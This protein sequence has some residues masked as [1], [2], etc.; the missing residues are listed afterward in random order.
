MNGIAGVCAVC[1]ASTSCKVMNVGCDPLTLRALMCCRVRKKE[2]QLKEK[3][4]VMLVA[5]P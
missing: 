2:S 3:A 5:P 1:P 4:A